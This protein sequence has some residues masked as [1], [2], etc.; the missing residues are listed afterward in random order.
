VSTFSANLETLSGSQAHPKT[1]E[2]WAACRKDLEPPEQAM[3]QYVNWSKSLDGKPVFVAYPGG[4]DFLF[5]YGYLIKFV[6]EPLITASALSVGGCSKSRRSSFG[7]YGVA[8]AA[9]TVADLACNS[10]NLDEFR[11][12]LPVLIDNLP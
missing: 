7:Y 9:D 2:W 11:E 12:K 4:F 1:A 8:N 5:V 6:G 10:G 3:T